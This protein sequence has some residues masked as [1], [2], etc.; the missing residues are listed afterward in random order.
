MKKLISF[1][2]SGIMAVTASMTSSIVTGADESVAVTYT[3]QD[4]KNLQH[5]NQFSKLD[6][7]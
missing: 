6:R 7:I 1:L 4:V 3:I 5:A 2:V